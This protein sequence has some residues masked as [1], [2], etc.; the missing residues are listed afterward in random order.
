MCVHVCAGTHVWVWVWGR[1]QLTVPFLGYHWTYFQSWSLI[2]LES[3]KSRG[4]LLSEPQC[5][6]THLSFS[7]QHLHYRFTL[8]HLKYFI[9]VMEIFITIH[10]YKPSVLPGKFSPWVFFKNLGQNQHS[11]YSSN[12]IILDFL[13]LCH[14]GLNPRHAKQIL[15]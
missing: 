14:Q 13:F 11:R 4:R 12:L 1:V 3:T 5:P 10:V 9:S 15:H 8:P 2:H 7:P 6:P